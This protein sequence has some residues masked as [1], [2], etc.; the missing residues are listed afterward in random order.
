MSEKYI[1]PEFQHISPEQVTEWNEKYEKIEPLFSSPEAFI[2]L[3]PREYQ[4]EIYQKAVKENTIAVLDTG[5][6]KTLISVL[7]IKHILT[8]E[9][10]KEKTIPNYK[11]KL[12]FFL[13]ERV[14]LVF[15]QASVIEANC[16][17]KVETMCGDMNVD[18]WSAEKWRISYDNSDICVMTS[19]IFLDTLR[20]AFL[21][22]E[23]TSLIVFD[24]CHHAVK[25]HSYKLIMEEFY[26]RTTEENKPK[27]F[28]MTASPINSSTTDIWK[29]VQD[30]EKA[31]H[32]KVYMALSSRELEAAVKKPSE[33]VQYYSMEV[34][35]N[36]PPSGVDC[37]DK[38]E[39]YK[40]F[41]NPSRIKLR[42]D[43]THL[44]QRIE[45]KIAPVMGWD[46][47]IYVSDSILN[48]MGPWCVDR[49]WKVMLKGA[50]KHGLLT[51]SEYTKTYSLARDESRRLEEAYDE[52]QS[53]TAPYPD[54]NNQ[55]LFTDKA[56]ALIDCLLG[57]FDDDSDNF[58]GII[59]VER[60]HTAV[61]IKLLI[62]GLNNFDGKAKCDILIGH[63]T[64]TGGDVKMKFRSQNNV[65]ERFRSGDINLM[66]AT[67]IGEEGLDIQSCNYVIRFDLFKTLIAYIQSRGRA[68]KKDSKYVML[69]NKQDTKEIKM[70][71][72]FRN[73]EQQMKDCYK[74][75]PPDRN[76]ANQFDF[77][78]SR[79][80]EDKNSCPE[81]MKGA[82][83]VPGTRALITLSSSIALVYFY[84][85]TL[86][87]DEFCNFQPI[88]TVTEID[89]IVPAF[90]CT[91]TLPI[92]AALRKF[93]CIDNSKMDA[94]KQVSLLACIELHKCGAIDD[95]LM[96]LAKVK[97]ELTRRYEEEKDEYGKQVGSRSREDFYPISVPFFWNKK[98]SDDNS[99]W[100][101]LFVIEGDD[102]T[103]PFR[104]M[105]LVTKN[106]LP[107]IPAFDFFKDNLKFRVRTILQAEKVEFKDDT[108]IKSLSNYTLAVTQSIVQKQFNCQFED[109]PYF[110]APLVRNVFP[111]PQK[112]LIVK[113]LETK[114]D[115]KEVNR[116]ISHDKKRRIPLAGVDSA[117]KDAIVIDVAGNNRHYFVEKVER[118]MSVLSDIPINLDI[119][120]REYEFNTFREYYSQHEKLPLKITDWGQPLLRVDRIYRSKT[121]TF[122]NEEAKS[123]K[124][125]KE[126]VEPTLNVLWL[127]PELCYLHCISA[128]V[129]RTL[130]ILPTIMIRIDSILH[131]LDA[132]ETLGLPFID[133]DLMLEAYTASSARM[134]MD[135]QRLEFLGDS[136]LKFITT[137]RAFVQFPSFNEYDLTEER[138]S[139]I[140]NKALF[141][142]AKKLHIY[143]YLTSQNI[144][145]RL[146]RPPHFTSPEDSPEI[147]KK[148]K[149]QKLSDKTLAD[150]V[151]STLGATYLSNR[152]LNQC[153]TACQSLEVPLNDILQ[154]SDFQT[155][156]DKGL[157]AK[158]EYMMRFQQKKLN[159]CII[160]TVDTN[161]E[162]SDISRIEEILGY[163]FRTPSLATEALTHAS[164]I[165]SNTGS[166][167]RLEFL[168]DAVLDY[169]VT[170]YLF[171]TYSLAPPGI[172]HDLRKS[173]VNN[174]ILS[175][176]CIQLRLS[177][178]IRHMSDRLVGAMKDFELECKEAQ[179]RGV[180]V[181]EY[182]L[183]FNAPK[184]L[185]DVIESL[186]GA[187]FVDSQFDV[188]TI[189]GLFERLIQPL[190]DKHIS[191]ELMKVHPVGKWKCMIQELRCT[192][193]EIRYPR[194]EKKK[195]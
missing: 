33:S 96:P 125:Q 169:C 13:T 179:R 130:E 4:N 93:E 9:R 108:K 188:N 80:T 112:V 164:C 128:S 45:S 145:L 15:Q 168:G 162:P 40:T 193:Y 89:P 6:G 136:V 114:I 10:Q 46:E 60:R 152:D 133:K 163:R 44:T 26:E 124:L 154:W 77:E 21:R 85:S 121:F 156:Y 71:P 173:S 123:R 30:L 192:E 160:G 19:Q 14:S 38:K 102:L 144:P 131:A 161:T 98:V 55:N 27:I 135:Y 157:L 41:N 37:Q 191:I 28:G 118:D 101:S 92:N 132:Q 68:R 126:Q 91:L 146:W 86:P 127:V 107:S 34:I 20:K 95:H 56:R 151:E 57:I 185:S 148:L 42:Y 49:L 180:D 122:S 36:I 115:W 105:C 155:K 113:S 75:L 153:L 176:L 32:S 181:G 142:T 167:Q 16:D 70:L 35:N 187:V 66:I 12:I 39:H 59:F 5:A 141:K 97:K 174:E 72:K 74:H 143:Q 159:G 140:S 137:I 1:D 106:P 139:M 43:R 64:K 31:L 29:G 189:N 166:Y 67:S 111:T 134:E 182:W 117:C 195:S 78:D 76:V 186:L 149:F 52:C 100:M 18:N 23:E 61:A 87:S 8:I 147:I 177:G 90:S 190:V 110:F 63:G 73:G 165:D 88:Y 158:R 58:C 82:Y 62:E 65:I 94:K 53:E 109:M 150:V 83:E 104:S 81:S 7:L 119:S 175:V 11:K 69:V 48:I 170:N 47:C 84:C 178:H 25:R 184:V 17:A 183:N 129:Y 50:N 171:Q 99:Y 103:R 2:R 79:S 22:L 116:A 54:V 24:E 172:L 194:G 3:S 51:P 138:M 120:L